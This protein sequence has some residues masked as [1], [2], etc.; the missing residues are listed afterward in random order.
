MSSVL[1][2]DMGKEIFAVVNGGTVA[3]GCSAVKNVISNILSMVDELTIRTYC[4][5]LG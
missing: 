4:Q 2:M 5:A 1:Q 3:V